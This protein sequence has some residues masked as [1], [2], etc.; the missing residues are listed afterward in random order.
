MTFQLKTISFM[1]MIVFCMGSH[2]Q[3]QSEGSADNHRTLPVKSGPEPCSA[4]AD[5]SNPEYQ[6]GRYFGESTEWTGMEVQ[7]QIKQ[8]K[9]DDIQ[10]LKAKGTPEYYNS[11][12]KKLPKAIVKAGTVDVDG[13]SGATLSCN[14]LKSAVAEALKKAEKH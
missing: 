13:I 11:V 3:N 8:G 10:V 2:A 6:D 12:I 14:S 4:K 1:L 5:I 9:I 7:V